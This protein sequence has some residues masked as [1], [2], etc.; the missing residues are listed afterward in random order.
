MIFPFLALKR[1]WEKK[2]L[3]IGNEKG[4]IEGGFYQPWHI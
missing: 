4:F 1:G 2:A 3:P